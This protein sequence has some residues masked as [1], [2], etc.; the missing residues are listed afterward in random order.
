MIKNA[1]KWCLLRYLNPADHDPRT[2]IKTD[3]NLPKKLILTTKK[4][5]Q[6]QGL[7]TNSRKEFH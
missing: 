7:L 6:N 1:F 2:I 4:S 5:S 3:N